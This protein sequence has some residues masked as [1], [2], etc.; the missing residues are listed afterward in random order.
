MNDRTLHRP[1]EDAFFDYT[2]R[3][4]AGEHPAPGN[5]LEATATRVQQAL[6]A[7]QPES[8]A[9][10]RHLKQSL[11]KDIMHTT[12]YNLASG[13]PSTR[14]PGASSL[15]T[16]KS[17]PRAFPRM[18]WTGT[19]N[20]ALAVLIVAALFG[21]WRGL[22]DPGGPS[23]LATL[24][25]ALMQES[26]PEMEDAAGTPVT[27][28]DLSGNIPLV[29][30]MTSDE[31]PFA[32][33]SLSVVHADPM[34]GDPRGVLT[35]GCPG[36]A[37]VVLAENVVAAWAGPWPGIVG[38]YILPPD[39]EDPAAAT[40]AF[41]E[42]RTGTTVRF[43]L[44][45]EEV[46]LGLVVTEGSPWVIGESAEDPESLVVADLRTMEIR[47]LVEVMSVDT[48]VVISADVSL[49]VSTPADD[50]TVAIGFR[51]PY[52]ED[53]DS[54]TL[55]QAPDTPGNLMILGD[56]FDDVSWIDVPNSLPR[57]SAV[58]LSPEGSYA[59]ITSMG[60]GDIAS[61]SYRYGLID[62]ADGSLVGQSGEIPYLDNPLAVWVQE[63]STIAYLDGSR[64]ETL[65]VDGGGQPAVAFEADS[66]LYSL[67][68]T[69]NAAVVVAS[70][71]RDHGGDAPAT[72]TAQ[73]MVYSID[74]STGA[75]HEFTGLDASA[76]VGW[77]TDAGA[78]VMYSWE[79]TNPEATTY[80]VFDPITG[81]QIGEIVDAP[82]AQVSE[83]TRP[84]LGL[85]SVSISADGTVEVIALGTQ[86]IY[87]FTLYDSGLTMSRIESPEGLLAESFLTATVFLSP[88]GSLLSLTGDEDEGRT[89]YMIPLDTP[90][91]G[92]TGF[93]NNVPGERGEGLITFVNTGSD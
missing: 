54:G 90:E 28:C 92:W 29:P 55:R 57:A 51:H 78:L 88:D 38:V 34:S 48:G 87:S 10:P 30:D 93:P 21:A 83:R 67:K 75:V 56:S 9:M 45:S 53:I 82:P 91:A 25:A 22:Q 74:I 17:F 1:A 36:E 14:I 43:S 12:T 52:S 31:P 46:T 58:S 16:R 59:A 11:W 18:M 76:T 66:Q 24:P 72:Q 44:G 7:N 86:H 50:G 6:R 3:M 81:D 41:V 63:G 13:T 40:P 71:H 61:E 47:P 15:P 68:T 5:D 33:T 37:S 26:T 89:R 32:M 79:D 23:E 85:H 35:L 42:V 73:D 2:D 62:L 20:V 64:L 65:A 4:A 27:S 70:T 69:W 49:L 19:A 80:A 8:P 77:V 60:E 39:V 84:T